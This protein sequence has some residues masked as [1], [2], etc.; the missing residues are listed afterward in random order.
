MATAIVVVSL[1]KYLK[2]SFTCNSPK[3][4]SIDLLPFITTVPCGSEL[5]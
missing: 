1:S 5:N 3:F 4:S 2:F